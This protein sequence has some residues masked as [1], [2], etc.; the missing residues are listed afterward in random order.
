MEGLESRL[1]LGLSAA[2]EVTSDAT[3]LPA[4]EP[5]ALA[6]RSASL[7]LTRLLEE[8]LERSEE[9]LG[10]ARDPASSFARA[11]F[12]SR[13]TFSV[14]LLLAEASLSS[15][16][17]VSRRDSSPATA[18]ESKDPHREPFGLRCG[19]VMLETRIVEVCVASITA[20]VLIGGCSRVALSY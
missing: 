4:F 6:S 10:G 17:M 18:P 12:A 7:S 14:A 16:S 19:E 2:G 1:V 9:T 20:S 5:V 13:S 8:L 11:I 3:W 15:A